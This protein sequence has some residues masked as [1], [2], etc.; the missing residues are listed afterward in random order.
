MDLEEIEVAQFRKLLK[1]IE[2]KAS[3]RWKIQEM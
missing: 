1:D 2:Q 3:K